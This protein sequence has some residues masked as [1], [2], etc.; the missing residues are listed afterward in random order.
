MFFV[1]HLFRICVP[2]DWYMSSILILNLSL[3]ML[4]SLIIPIIPLNELTAHNNLFNGV[5]CHFFSLRGNKLTFSLKRRFALKKYKGPHNCVWGVVIRRG[6]NYS[7]A[8]VFRAFIFKYPGSQII[9]SWYFERPPYSIRMFDIVD[10]ASNLN[11]PVF[12]VE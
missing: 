6:C 9:H 11:K 7:F 10:L 4:L 2:S 8:W 3:L 1:V 12:Y 5:F